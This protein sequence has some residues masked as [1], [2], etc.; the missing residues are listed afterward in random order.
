MYHRT[1]T[2]RRTLAVFGIV[3]TVLSCMQQSRALCLLAGCRPDATDL[4]LDADEEHEDDCC[5][6]CKGEV[7]AETHNDCHK[8]SVEGMPCSEPCSMCE[9][10]APRTAS[11]PIDANSVI[12]L[13]ETPLATQGVTCTSVT[14]FASASE[15]FYSGSLATCITLCRFLS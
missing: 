1:S 10:A 15:P 5:D 7:V 4:E 3:L 12:S 14:S 2:L 8:N 13:V 6:T 11:I 9:R